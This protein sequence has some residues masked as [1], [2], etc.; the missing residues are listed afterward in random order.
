V[1]T[2][3]LAILEEKRLVEWTFLLKFLL[4]PP[5]LTTPTDASTG[6]LLVGRFFLRA[7][8][9]KLSVMLCSNLVLPEERMEA[10]L[11]LPKEVFV[12]PWR[13][14]YFSGALD[15]VNIPE[16]CTHTILKWEWE[17]PEISEKILGSNIHTVFCTST[18]KKCPLQTICYPDW[19]KPEIY[20]SEPKSGTFFIGWANNLLRRELVQKYSGRPEFSVKL[21]ESY[22]NYDSKRNKEFEK[23]YCDGL[24]TSEFCLCPKGVGS[25]TRRF[26]EALAAGSIPILISDEFEL[27]RCWDWDNTIIRLSEKKALYLND[28]LIHHTRIPNKAERKE[29]CYKAHKFFTD[30]ANI[31]EYIRK[32]L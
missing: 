24:A 12:A 29:N 1:I 20:S 13:S 23:E 21:R 25:G 26:W 18:G 9:N 8:P 14:L 7:L 4:Q 11:N 32:C 16:Y 31:S 10:A 22:Y 5:A 27:P 6:S 19:V 30:P 2:M 17:I 15:R 3:L 28:A